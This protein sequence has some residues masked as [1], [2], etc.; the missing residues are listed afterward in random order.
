M[1][2]SLVFYVFNGNSNKLLTNQYVS[3]WIVGQMKQSHT[4]F[5]WAF[6]VSIGCVLKTFYDH[7]NKTKKNEFLNSHAQQ[8]TE[9]ICFY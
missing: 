9:Q 8:A 7:L 5:M 3:H 1:E 4:R 2:M 6:S